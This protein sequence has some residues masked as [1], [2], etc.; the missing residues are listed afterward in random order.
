MITNMIETYTFYL[1]HFR[2]VLTPIIIYRVADKK[3]LLRLSPIASNNEQL[4]S[5]LKM[6][7]KAEGSG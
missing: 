3:V 4:E 5:K 6:I 1:F 2:R 7:H